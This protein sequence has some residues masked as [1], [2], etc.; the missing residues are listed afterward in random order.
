VVVCPNCGEGN[1]ERARFCLACGT[2]LAPATAAGE[3][4][5]VVSVLFVDLVGFTARSDKADPEDVRATLRPYHT[6]V[7]REIERYGGTV[8]KFVGDAVMA[9]FG[10]PVAHEDDAERAVRSALRILGAIAELNEEHDLDL[11][12]RAAVATGEAVVS[13]GAQPGTGE[14]IATGDVVNTA[15]RLQSEAPVGGLVVNEQTFR[16]TRSAIDYEESPPVELKGK[17]EPV[18]LWRAIGTRSRF[19]VDTD[20]LAAG[21]FVGRQREL[22]LLQSTYERML[23]ESEIQLVTLIGEP[24]VGKTRLLAEFRQWVDDRPEIVFWR[25]GRCLPYGDGITF[26]ALGEI[27]KAHAGI[28]ESDRPADAAAKLATAVAEMEDSA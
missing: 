10:A 20:E 24:G 13:L 18:P 11:V 26:W 22:Q 6:R 8:E 27:V 19:G 4:R 25:Q 2:E 5:K 9:V 15:S 21:P 1:P 16:A 23:G 28:L 14:G 7:S 12:A 17:S 3:E